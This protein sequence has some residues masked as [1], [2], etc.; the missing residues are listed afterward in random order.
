MKPHPTQSSSN[1]GSPRPPGAGEPVRGAAG[2]PTEFTR[3]D[4]LRVT[5]LAGGGF[6]LGLSFV[7]DV[8]AQPAQALDNTARA[9]TP[10]PFIRITPDNVITIV[11]KNP[12]IGQG[13][14]T[15][16]PMIVAEEL[17]VDFSKI[18][19]EQA[20]LNPQLGAQ[21]AGGS[22]STPQN[23]DLL[24]KAGATAR[25]MLIEA[26]AQTWNVPASELTAE[27]GT[28]VHRASGR[29]LTYG[30]L[31]T[32]AATLPLPDEGTIKLKEPDEFTLLGSRVGGVDNPAIVTGQP[33]FGL[34]QKVAGMRYAVFEK[35]P[36]FGGKV[37]SANLDQIKA[38]PGVRD[39]FVLEGGGNYA[40]LLS[41][42][43]I[44]ADSTWAA[45]KAR[46]AL[47]VTWDEGSG[48]NQ[49]SNAFDA[50]AAELAAQPG[51]VLRNE[52]DVAAAFAG[53]AKVVEAKYVYPYL[54][55]ATLEPMNA[56][57]WPTPDGGMEILAPTQTPGGAQDLVANTLKIPK[58]KIK[59]RFTR[60]GGGFGRRLAND[61]VV[62][63]AAIAQKAGAPVK[64]TWTREQDTQHGL[65]RPCGWHHF[66]GA[67]DAQGKL[68]AWQDRFV[69]VGLNSDKEP[70]SSAR[71]SPSE[72]PSRFVPNFRLEQ[73]I[74]NTN[75]PTGPLRAP[76]SN[77]LGFVIQCFIDE[78]AHAAGRDQV[79]FRLDLLGD[80][81]QPG[82]DARSLPYDAPRMAHVL[83]TV[84]EKAGWGKKLPRGTGQ[85]VA[86]FFSHRGYFAEVAEVTVAPDGT[87][88]VPRVTVVGDV[89]P[90]M[91]LSG[92]ENQVQGSVIDA[93]GAAW[94]QEVTLDRGRI[95]QANFDTYPLLRVND[96]PTAVDV[97]FIQ[98]KNPPTGL[99]EPG[100]PPLPPAVCNAIFAATGKRVRSLPLTKQDLRWS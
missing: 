74:V 69:T 4:F 99:G 41:G 75:V 14:K 62:E 78:L 1:D 59:V 9:F 28:V 89:G 61:Y 80:K 77:A 26:A 29:R 82:L 50:R 66:K 85:G 12:E 5:A 8:L 100:Y 25:T 22:L 40:G 84:A 7:P 37:V 95:T 34:D 2:L 27:K 58:E 19:I 72:F 21:F 42:V 57:A 76:G 31:A 64:L 65:Y 91:N 67:V 73:A 44:L 33:L 56:M 87:L 60:I 13:I 24:R 94:L 45:F 93:L 20:P 68:V 15:S 79:Q 90:I 98:S 48:A 23:Y 52:G 92:A 55:H 88:K 70:G 17:E 43:A 81:I 39:A 53:A 86:F 32:K 47:R 51:Q 18:V 97:H 6:A 96:A 71:M 46:T 35:C 10:N 63:A 49:S 36:V 3:R 83:R 16:L 54:H 38:M 30:E 11:A